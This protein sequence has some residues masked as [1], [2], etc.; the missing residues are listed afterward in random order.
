[1]PFS[2]SPY[3]PRF[4]NVTSPTSCPLYVPRCR[5]TQESADSEAA[6]RLF[7]QLNMQDGR[8][9]SSTAPPPPSYSAAVSR[10]SLHCDSLSVCMCLVPSSSEI[11]ASVFHT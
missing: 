11:V 7:E 2:F 1:V 6:R 4:S 8:A 10:C 9:P 3:V 5:V